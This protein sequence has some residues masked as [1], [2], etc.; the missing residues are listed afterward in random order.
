MYASDISTPFNAYLLSYAFPPILSG[1]IMLL[2][3]TLLRSRKPQGTDTRAKNNEIPDEIQPK[4][5][6]V[7]KKETVHKEH[8][9]R[10]I[11]ASF[12]KIRASIDTH[13]I[14]Y[15][16][17]LGVTTFYFGIVI[18]LLTRLL[19]SKNQNTRKASL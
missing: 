17:K 11:G 10:S 5:Q 12:V 18:L 1:L 4:E 9:H 16:Q 8:T 14:S 6:V 13:R 19:I 15:H 7:K 2:S 3:C